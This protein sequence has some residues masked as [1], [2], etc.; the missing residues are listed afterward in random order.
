MVTTGRAECRAPFPVRVAS[1]SALHLYDST[2]A[3]VA[4]SLE[5]LSCSLE[6]L[7]CSLAVSCCLGF[8]ARSRWFLK[9]KPI[10]HV[11]I[12]RCNTAAE[13]LRSDVESPGEYGAGATWEAPRTR[14]MTMTISGQTDDHF[15][16]LWI[17]KPGAV[18]FASP[19]CVS[20]REVCVCHSSLPHISNQQF[21]DMI[22]QVT[23]WSSQIL[24][25]MD[26]VNLVNV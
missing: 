9:W 23:G 13:H 3:L 20:A 1:S 16:G 19:L 5:L 8:A 21:G 25:V 4:C 10:G 15:I 24:Y 11:Q 6:L 14:T 12:T 22:R 7:S 18:Q 17:G 2:Q 26:V